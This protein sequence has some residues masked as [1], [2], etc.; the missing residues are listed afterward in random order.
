MSIPFLSD[1]WFAKLEEFGN[2]FDN[3][4]VSPKLSNF[5]VNVTAK[6]DKHEDR[7]F[8][9]KNG[10]FEKGHAEIRSLHL[11]MPIALAKKVFI[12]EERS[13]AVKGMMTGKIKASGDLTR[14]S[15]LQTVKPSEDQ[16]AMLE[17][18]RAITE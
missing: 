2:E 14:L 16:K 4:T 12:F 13:L 3:F 15:L 5:V 9:L 7:N 1:E 18:L 10:R 6:S 8:A 17:K 11:T